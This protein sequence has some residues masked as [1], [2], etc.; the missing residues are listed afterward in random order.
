VDLTQFMAVN[1]YFNRLR[2][3]PSIA[4]ALA[5]EFVLYQEQQARRAA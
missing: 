4:R 1:A 2:E 5:E 3:R